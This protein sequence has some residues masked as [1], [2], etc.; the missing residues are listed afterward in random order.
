M[1]GRA[2]GV[3]VI[4]PNWNRADLLA[5]LLKH[6][7]AQSYP[8]EDILVVDNGSTDESTAVAARE[9][10]CVVE[11][12][13]NAGF[14]AAVNRGISEA[15]SPW[16]A[17][18]NNDVTVG[19]HWLASL[20]DQA[21]RASAAFACGKLLRTLE[22]HVIDG[23]Y[24]AICR[25]AMP[26][27]CGAG[28]VDGPIWDQR[29]N[30][31]LVSMTATLFH[32]SAFDK[33]GLLDE[34]FESYLEDVDFSLRCVRAGLCGVYVPEAVGYHR[35]S[36]TLGAWHKATVRLHAR[37]HILLVSKHFRGAPKWP[38][39]VAHV[40]WMAAAFRRGAGL[41]SIRGTAEGLRRAVGAA[42]CGAW[43]EIRSVVEASERDIRDIQIETGFDL[44]WKLYFRLVR[45]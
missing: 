34:Q 38:A 17:I 15:R 32:R 16:V 36:A 31:H 39:L 28:R 41:A 8:I 18:M 40:L 6:L 11:M 45:S 1:T 23:T 43:H 13:R 37:N 24:D 5:E 30:V 20:I 42:D 7:R 35:G 14:A 3:T 22:P 2:G 33:V 44:Y 25:G 27:R 19:P 29:R 9:G 12:G 26:W 10:A 21:E 4:I